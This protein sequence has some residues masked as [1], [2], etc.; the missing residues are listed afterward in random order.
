[1][2]ND[3]AEFFNNLKTLVYEHKT[4]YTRLLRSKLY[5]EQYHELYD[6]VIRKTPL[7]NSNEYTLITRVYWVL[8]GI[9]SF[10]DTRCCCKNCN[11]NGE[12]RNVKNVFVGYNECCSKKCMHESAQ[13][14]ERYKQTCIK[15]F[16]CENA[17]QNADIKDK[18]AHTAF[19]NYG[20]KNPAQSIAV[21]KHIEQTN[22]EKYNV[23]YSFQAESVKEKSK[24]TLLSNYGV[25]HPL[26][27]RELRIKAS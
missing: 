1:M 7:L 10:D 3:D 6:Y 4:S 8:N 17:S 15:R 23:E 5:H 9:I 24:K 14:K 21:K 11:K 2:D 19:K 22:L 26:Q 27:N 25:E 16:G 20:V 18:K 13:R 12:H